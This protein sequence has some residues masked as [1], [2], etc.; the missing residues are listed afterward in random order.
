MENHIVGYV[1]EWEQESYK[2][3]LKTQIDFEIFL[4]TNGIER[5]NPHTLI[6]SNNK[7]YFYYTENYKQKRKDVSNW[8]FWFKEGDNNYLFNILETWQ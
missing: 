6:K 7:I 2:K 8:R 3:K 4:D 1:V 5:P